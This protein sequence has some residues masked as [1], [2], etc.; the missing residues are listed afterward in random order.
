MFRNK[1]PDEGAKKAI[2]DALKA[3][4]LDTDDFFKEC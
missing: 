3:Y 2:E 4:N 1:N